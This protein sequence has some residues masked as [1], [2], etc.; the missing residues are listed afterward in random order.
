[1]VRGIREAEQCLG[2]AEKAPTAAEL[3]TAKV[4]RRSLVAA[5]PISE[6]EVIAADAI[7]ARRPG[8]GLSPM[9]YWAL[10]GTRAVRAYHIGEPIE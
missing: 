5:R 1:M 4:A 3:K 6:G 10:V 9:D 7:V 2:S 8:T